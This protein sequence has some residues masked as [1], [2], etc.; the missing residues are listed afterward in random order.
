MSKL[1]SL[2]KKAVGN[3]CP[4]H[5]IRSFHT[6]STFLDRETQPT[7]RAGHISPWMRTPFFHE[8]GPP[9][10]ID[11]SLQ[12]RLEE[13][14]PE[15]TVSGARVDIGFKSVE[16]EGQNKAQIAD[17]RR[18]SRNNKELERAAREGTLNV[19]LSV[20]RKQWVDSGSVYEDILNA[21]EL[22]G[23]FEDL[24]EH[25]YFKP[26]MMLDIKY[27]YQDVLVPVHR[28]NVIKPG[29]AS[30]APC[31]NYVSSDSSLWCLAMTGPDSGLSGDGEVLHWLVGNIKGSDL[32]SG[33]TLC[34]YLQPFP[35]FGTG[36]QRF[37]FI[38]YKQEGNIEFSDEKREE[39]NG[40]CLNARQF[41]TFDF[42]RKFQ[43]QL[44]P[45]GLAFYQ[46]DYESSLRNFFHNV[47]NMK[48][49]RYEYE[50][51]DWYVAP[52]KYYFHTNLKDGFD[53]FLDRHRDPKDIQREVLQIKLSHT[54]PFVGDTDAYIKYPGIHEV[55]MEEQFPPPIGEKRLNP[56]QSFKIAQ[57][58]RNAIQKQRLKQRY[59]KSSDH[60]D[61]RKDP[62]MNS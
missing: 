9:P 33:E 31:V 11:K 17:W 54:D 36:Y 16:N 32:S 52:W 2:G 50:Y 59:Y 46:S 42:Y 15:D 37:A 25:G 23:L 39:P 55:E 8:R 20:V 61:L 53:E 3:V 47:L 27:Q 4:R 43:D 7:G 40:V 49:P 6:C 12:E 22:Y 60:R 34:S 10:G 44:T 19:D 1:A 57:W 45:A 14:Y 24:F 5:F 30:N 56:K 58:R 35:A 51:P 48:E 41:R 26:C 62:S 38:L 13:L 29:E 28:G 21:A 18:K